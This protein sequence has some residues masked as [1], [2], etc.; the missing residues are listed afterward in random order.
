MSREC[1]VPSLAVI[2]AVDMKPARMRS[3][4]RNTLELSFCD[5]LPAAG[6]AASFVPHHGS[7]FAKAVS[8]QGSDVMTQA[9]TVPNTVAI[10]AP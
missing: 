3:C 2:T 5:G 8:L 10:A 6:T 4:S 9:T 1:P 7:M